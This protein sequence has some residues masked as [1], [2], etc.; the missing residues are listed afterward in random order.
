[1]NLNE[2]IAWW[3]KAA[4]HNET[5][6]SLIAFGVATG[7]KIARAD[8]GAKDRER[9]KHSGSS[10]DDEPLQTRDHEFAGYHY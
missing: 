3:T 2:E 7:L 6:A 5:G 8:Y 4:F 10:P 9:N 1:M